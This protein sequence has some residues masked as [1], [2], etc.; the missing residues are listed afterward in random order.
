[1]SENGLEKESVAPRK[2]VKPG[3]EFQVIVP[4][5]MSIEALRADALRNY[6]L[7]IHVRAKFGPTRID[8]DGKLGVPIQAIDDN[9][10]KG[11]FRHFPLP[12]EG[13]CLYVGYF[14]R[15]EK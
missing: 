12:A 7:P 8:E 4:G 5:S 13:F 11:D 10:L 9:A 6:G 1:M 15:S 2:E 14:E 3:D